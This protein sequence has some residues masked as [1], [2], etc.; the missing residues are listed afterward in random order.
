MRMLMLAGALA[1][2]LAAP[3]ARGGEAEEPKPKAEAPKL[4]AEESA[5]L[6]GLIKQLG[7]DEWKDREAASGEIEK[8]G[9]KALPALEEAAKSSDAEISTRAKALIAK[10]DPPKRPNW[11]RR[12]SRPEAGR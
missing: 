6:A 9:K 11:T 7:S 5:R 10:L 1:A 8:L 2:L 12:R 3:G 4:S